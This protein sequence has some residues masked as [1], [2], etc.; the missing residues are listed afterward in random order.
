MSYKWRWAHPHFFMPPELNDIDSGET[1]KR[2]REYYIIL[3]VVAFVAIITYV[4]SHI[5]VIS[6]DLPVPTNL[7]ILGIINI[8]IILLVLLVFLILRNAVKLFF[9]SRRNVMG[10]RLK[11]KLVTA[12]VVLT[13]VPTC[14]LFFA[15]IGFV[16][17]S[18]D[19]WFA[20]RVEDSLKHSLEL[21]Q[22]YY[23]DTSAR[24][25]N[26]AWHASTEMTSGGIP[27]SLSSVTGDKGFSTVE[28]YSAKG[29]RTYY[30]IA[31]K[32]N[33][34][35]VPDVSLLEIERTAKEGARSFVQTFA[36]GDVVRGAVPVY[37]TD[38]AFRSVIV[39]SYY[40]PENLVA[41]MKDI[42]AAF[43]GYQQLKLLKNPVKTGYFTVLLLITLVILFFSVWIGQYLAKEITMPIAELAE[44][45]HAVA[46]GNLDY[47]IDIDSNDE[48][49]LLVRSFNR[50]TEDL[51]AGK[52]NIESA[53]KTLRVTNRE[54]ERRRKYIEI[55]LG[56]IP[57]GVMSMDKDG[58]ITS[59]N[60]VAE[61]MLSIGSGGAEGRLYTEA[62]MPAYASFLADMVLELTNL[63]LKSIERQMNVDLKDRVT[64]VLVNL[65]AIRDENDEYLG[66][67]AVMDDVTH[68]VK[69]QRM[70]AWKE[71]AKRIAHEIK[72]PL[73]PI[74]LSAQ[75]LRKKYIGKLPDDGV[76]F[77]ECTRTIINQVDELKTLV[78]EFS[79]FARMPAVNPSM[80]DLNA[81]IAE[82]IAL[83]G[84][85]H[86]NIAFESAMDPMLPLLQIDREQIKRV[87]INLMDNAAASIEG[88]GA[89][90][91]ETFY[92]RELNIVRMEISDTGS[93]IAAEDKARLF[94][95]YFSRKKLGTGLGLAIVSNI[96]ADHNGYIRVKDN[97]PKGTRFVIELPARQVL[98]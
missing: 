29:Q 60:R 41:K 96:I 18:I 17:K 39:V 15:A 61:E 69:T 71:V 12:F 9:S 36:S 2:K 44:G 90:K 37:G 42:S 16:N 30:S 6:G 43:E 78:N 58:R 84:A 91:V 46:S 22:N 55:V 95:P 35:M 94:E 53:N 81:V 74:Q 56:N 77:D 87:L 59:L 8:N 45:T 83:Y 75:R 89:V 76:A 33:R 13:I 47:R 10:S 70:F 4:E 19:S 5:E 66:V 52:G 72:N 54:L 21:A 38:G 40:L 73:T 14:V 93:G 28:I 25:L 92:D 34:N 27:D 23:K 68:L 80:N 51:K 63:N 7:L 98:I 32:V 57:A 1:K 26:A 20:I 31:D 88:E 97:V 79:S 64:A 3:A 50:M 11:T 49:G 86:K 48:I 85:G 65:T 62:L 82:T 24:T 67:V